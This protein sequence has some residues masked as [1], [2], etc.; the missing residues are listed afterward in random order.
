MAEGSMHTRPDTLQTPTDKANPPQPIDSAKCAHQ[1]EGGRASP[2][3]CYSAAGADAFC[4]RRELARALRL[5][6]LR[7]PAAPC[8][9]RSSA[10]VALKAWPRWSVAWPSSRICFHTYL[11]HVGRGLCWAARRRCGAMEGKA[12]WATATR[13]PSSCP[14]RSRLLLASASSLWR[15]EATTASPPPP[16]ALSLLGARVSTAA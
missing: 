16:T 10:R 4:E 3:P 14:R 8:P 9:S 12:S 6:P 5:P 7:S 15:R 1:T 11:I 13:R 2:R